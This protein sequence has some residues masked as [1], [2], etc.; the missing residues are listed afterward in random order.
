MKIPCENASDSSVVRSASMTGVW[1]VIGK[2]WRGEGWSRNASMLLMD[3][4]HSWVFQ[5][6]PYS[7]P[8]KTLSFW[9]VGIPF[10]KGR[11]FQ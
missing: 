6:D 1:G 7:Y 10:K 4:G 8:Q 11:G 3:R 2:D 9:G 5:S